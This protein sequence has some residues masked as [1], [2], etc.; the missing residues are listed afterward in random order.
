[1]VLIALSTI[2]SRQAEATKTTIKNVKQ[3][4]HYLA[5]N[6]EATLQYYA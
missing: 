3:L 4:L 1:M 5:W 6:Q 2:T